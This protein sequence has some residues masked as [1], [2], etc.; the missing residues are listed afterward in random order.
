M[1]Q[2]VEPPD[3]LDYF[4]TPPWATRALCEFLKLH[5]KLHGQT[6]WE[7]ACGGGHMAR[8]LAEYFERVYSSDVHP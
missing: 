7:P 6:C 3:S 4:P 8:P 2:R 5:H 1:A